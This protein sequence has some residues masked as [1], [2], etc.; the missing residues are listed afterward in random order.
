MSIEIIIK[1]R[2]NVEFPIIIMDKRENVIY[3]QNEDGFWWE[4]TYDDN[5][6]QL[7]C[8]NSEGY[9]TESAY[10]DNNNKI[11][12][13]ASDGFCRQSTYDNNKNELTYS[14]SNGNYE[15]KRK[16]VTKEEYEVFINN[17]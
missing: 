15:I 2:S 4:S 12:F 9:C 10:D 5:N 8:K 13:K 7:T 17:N 3:K 6:N 14:D 11:N 1:D 16:K